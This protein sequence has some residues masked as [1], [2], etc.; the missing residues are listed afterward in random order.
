MSAMCHISS[1]MMAKDFSYDVFFVI[2]PLAINL[3]CILLPKMRVLPSPLT[4]ARGERNQQ[5]F[6]LPFRFVFSS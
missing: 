5:Y 1:S 2:L 4:L 3:V 6:I